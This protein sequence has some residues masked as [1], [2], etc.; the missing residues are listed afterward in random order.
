MANGI[1]F[2]IENGEFCSFSYT[3]KSAIK[4]I[5]VP[6]NVTSIGICAFELASET[7]SIKLPNSL[8]TRPLRF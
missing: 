5:V 6:E 4:N 2:Y 1:E 3:D 8:N 7:E